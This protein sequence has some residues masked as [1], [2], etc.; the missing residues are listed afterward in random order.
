MKNAKIWLALSIGIITLLNKV[1]NFAGAYTFLFVGMF[2]LALAIFF[3]GFVSNGRN[4]DSE[5][6]IGKTLL[7]I[8]IPMVILDIFIP[9]N[10]VFSLT[11]PTLIFNE[12]IRL[13][14]RQVSERMFG[15]LI[16]L[17]MVGA[18]AFVVLSYVDAY[19]QIKGN[20]KLKSRCYTC[21]NDATTRD[22]DTGQMLCEKCHRFIHEDARMVT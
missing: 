10:V 2:F 5:I 17:V 9:Y 8:G 16:G 14:F 12:S 13:F 6:G 19:R 20:T 22:E 4:Y 1:V 11:I 21:R 18:G 3:V 7:V 15:A